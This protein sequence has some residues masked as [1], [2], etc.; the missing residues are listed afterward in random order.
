MARE[1]AEKKFAPRAA[2]VDRN[3]SF[4]TENYR[5]MAEAGLLGICIP[6]AEGGMGAD[7]KTYMIAAAE[8]GRYC[9]ATAL[10]F[11]MHVSSCLWTGFLLDGLD[12]SAEHR[13]QHNQ[14]RQLHYRRILDEGKIYSQPFSEGGAAAAGLF[15]SQ[16]TNT[17][18]ATRCT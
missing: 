1:L 11:N 5:D 18:A 17:R 2:A 3:A 4:P 8:I 10:T 15:R 16:M 7:L 6:K 14:M 12:M 9:G 13:K